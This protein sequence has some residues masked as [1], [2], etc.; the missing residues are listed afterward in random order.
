MPDVREVYEMVTK[1]KPS[2]PGALD[3]Q[4]TRQIRRMR[5]RK[6]GTVAMTALMAIGVALVLANYPEGDRGA[7]GNGPPLDR[8]LTPAKRVATDFLRAFD[9][10]DADLALSHLA[11]DADVA[12]VVTSLGD[13]GL[14][15]TTDELPLFVSMLEA[16][17][18]EQRFPVCEES[19]GSATS[20]TRFHCDVSFSILGS[21]EFGRE[22]FRGSYF[23]VSVRDGEIQRASVHWNTERMSPQA[24]EPFAHWVSKAYPD[25]AASMYED[26]TYGAARV[27]PGSIRLWERRVREFVDV[28]TSL[29]Q[30]PPGRLSQVVGSVRFS[31]DVPAA[32]W[33]PFGTI[34]INKSIVGPQGAE[35]ILYWT[36]IPDGPNT[37]QCFPLA[38][39][40]DLGPTGA[41]AAVVATAPGTELV[42][43]PSNVTVGGLPAKHVVLRV[44]EDA[45]CDPGYFHTWH[46]V[47]WGA[48]WPETRV[49]DTIRVWIVDVAG[50]RLYFG[51][52]TNPDADAALVRQVDGIVSSIRFG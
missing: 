29:R 3:R 51:A 17:A 49:G 38:S 20:G 18:Y 52:L 36:S 44:R 10:L 37:R 26:S 28:N 39:G 34:S 11:D 48:S 50:T 47:R 32:G 19:G 25:D 33:E 40:G 15:G 4:R 27:S 22:A 31:F 21:S 43:G 8:A 30:A 23:D 46:D 9:I 7:V 41:V 45:G 5:N 14:R 1:Q 16:M 2:D 24:W 42:A 12:G 35:A 6:I 13:E